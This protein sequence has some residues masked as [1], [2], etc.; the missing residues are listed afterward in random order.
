MKVPIAPSLQFTIGDR[1]KV[2]PE[3]IGTQEFRGKLATIIEVYSDGLCRI[4]FDSEIEISGCQ[5][6][7][8]TNINGQYLVLEPAVTDSNLSEEELEL[9]EFVRSAIAENDPATAKQVQGILKEV[10]SSGVADKEKVWGAL[11]ASEQA[12]FKRLVNSQPETEQPPIAPLESEPEQPS[13]PIAPKRP[14]S[15][16]KNFALGD[17]VV[18]ARDDGSMYEGAKGKVI[19]VKVQDVLIEFDKAVRGNNSATFN[20]ASTMLMKL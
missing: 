15:K 2:S 9:V 3:Y 12:A 13:A 11:M 20:L 19:K 16:H 17:R 6:K 8:A 5:P 10:R 4:E 1:V 14:P 18:V 7:K